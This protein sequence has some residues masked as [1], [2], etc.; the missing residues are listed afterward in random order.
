MLSVRT[1]GDETIYT[2]GPTH[3]QPSISGTLKYPQEFCRPDERLR[4]DEFMALL[5]VLFLQ[6]RRSAHGRLAHPYSVLHCR[7]PRS[8]V[9]SIPEVMGEILRH[10]DFDD[11]I[12]T[13]HISKFGRELVRSA[14][15][16]DVL[17]M[18]SQYVRGERRDVASFIELLQSARGYVLCHVPEEIVNPGNTSATR[19]VTPNCSTLQDLVI[20]VEDAYGMRMVLEWFWARGYVWW[21]GRNTADGVLTSRTDFAVGA[22]WPG[23]LMKVRLP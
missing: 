14:M 7:N 10:V 15:S 19:P 12:S 16:V 11:R 2:E 17:D 6:L 8:R 20:V 1:N 3:F 18:M 13:M 9:F 4:P 23:G 21:K 22:L 5:Y